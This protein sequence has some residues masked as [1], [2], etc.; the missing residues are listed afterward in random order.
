MAKN[1][2]AKYAKLTRGCEFCE[3]N[4]LIDGSR[5]ESACLSGIVIEMIKRARRIL[6]IVGSNAEKYLI[7]EHLVIFL[8]YMPF[9]LL[10]FNSYLFY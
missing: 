5:N 9:L 8:H 2:F 10:S 7:I 6:T 4:R 1:V 3:S